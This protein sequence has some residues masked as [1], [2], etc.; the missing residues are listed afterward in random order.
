M[1]VTLDGSRP[2]LELLK[3]GRAQVG[4]LTSPSEVDADTAGFASLPIAWRRVVVVSSAN[5]LERLTL[6]EL[7]AVFGTGVGSSYNRWGDLGLIEDWQGSPI[8]AAAPAEGF[9]LT[10]AFFRQ[11]V[12]SAHPLRAR[13]ARYGSVADLR[14]RVSADRRVLALAS[15][16]PKNSPEGKVLSLAVRADDP[17]YPPTPENISS[18]DYPLRMAL[19]IVY[20]RDSEATVGRLLVWLW[21]DAVAQILERTDLVPLPISARRLQVQILEKNMQKKLPK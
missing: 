21:G 18:G 2:G 1:T 13:V 3:S 19:R 15:H 17:A 10:T 11:T 20:R 12:L 4:L 7:A 6:P 9:G 5:P 8:S 16:W 14:Q